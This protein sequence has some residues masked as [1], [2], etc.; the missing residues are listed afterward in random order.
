M[1]YSKTLE[2]SLGLAEQSNTLR[3]PAHTKDTTYLL[4]S[5]TLRQ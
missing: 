2:F 5:D 3:N 4:Y 1:L